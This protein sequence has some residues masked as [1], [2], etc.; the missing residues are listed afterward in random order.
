LQVHDR[1]M[2]QVHDRGTLQVHDR[3]MLQVHDRGT[4]QVHDRGMLQVHDRGMLNGFY[5]AAW[6]GWSCV[7][8]VQHTYASPMVYNANKTSQ[9]F[10]EQM[11]VLA[12]LQ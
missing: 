7:R 9:S 10:H 6:S 5:L 12:L 1:G 11:P 4:L 8:L 2:L 3:G